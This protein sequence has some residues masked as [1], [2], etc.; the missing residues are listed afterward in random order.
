MALVGT[1]GGDGENRS[2]GGRRHDGRA[3]GLQA[4]QASAHGTG[5]V[6][7]GTGP[8]LSA[9]ASCSEDKGF[10]CDHGVL[11]FVGSRERVEVLFDEEL[12][13]RTRELVEGMK[14][15]TAAPHCS[16]AAGRQS[17][18][19]RCSLVGLCLPDEVGWL[20]ESA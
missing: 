9:G 15:T 2:V 18:C 14:A 3:G 19:P 12:V 7:T 16:A 11:Y 4:R 6:G 20:E 13:A 1:S 8:A 5:S 17:K 10:T